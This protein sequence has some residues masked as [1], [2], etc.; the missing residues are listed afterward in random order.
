MS[1]ER[2]VTDSEGFV[3]YVPKSD[4]NIRELALG[5]MSG[6]VFCDRMLDS[7]RDM[8]MVFMPLAFMDKP[9]IDGLIKLLEPKE[10]GGPHG[11]IYEWMGKAGPRSI[12]GM[13]IFTSLQTLSADDVARVDAM[14]EAI[15]AVTGGEEEE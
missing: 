1:D 10:E 3:A 12:N 11:M 15:N 8:S 5:L 4:K 9:A 7:P 13:P 6:S 2:I 14:I